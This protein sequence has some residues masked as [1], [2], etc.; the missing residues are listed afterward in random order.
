M[1]DT[2]APLRGLAAAFAASLYAAV[3]ASATVVRVPAD[4][5]TIQ[6]GVNAAAH[7]DTV[8]VAHGV[9]SGPGNYDLDFGGVDKTLLSE[10]G[11]EATIIRASDPGRGFFFGGGETRATVVRGFTV[12]EGHAGHGGGAYIG[13]G[14]SPTLT[15]VVFRD[16]TASSEGGAIYCDAGG[17]VL[18]EDTQFE[19]NS[20]LNGGAIACFNSVAFEVRRV[21][22]VGNSAVFWGGAI[23]STHYG[24]LILEDVHFEG[25]VATDGGAIFF[26]GHEQ[27]TM[28]RTTFVANS[29]TSTGGAVWTYGWA[30]LHLEHVTLVG[31]QAPTG[32]GLTIGLSSQLILT[33]SIIA[34]SPHGDAIHCAQ[35]GIAVLQCCDLFGNAGGD[36]TGCIADQ[37]GVD[38]N[39]SEDPLFCGSQLP[40][41][42]LALH[43]DSPCAPGP[44]SECGLIGARAVGCGPSVISET[45]WGRLKDTFR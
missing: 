20:A 5:P 22:F 36:W 37:A 8:L 9:Y 19:A 24:P 34:F 35:E 30:I 15:D 17:S 23:Y 10:A 38:G 2:H 29:A 39:L 18:L 14:S 3:V 25:N 33:H 27:P 16:N 44:G 28:Q 13:A 12:T 40:E 45:T 11:P 4:Q 26:S 6:A 41:D 1:R 31:N 43:E 42:P 21:S 7:G 32:A